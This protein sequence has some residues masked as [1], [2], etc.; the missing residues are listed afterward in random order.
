MRTT[1]APIARRGGLV[2]DNSPSGEV[3]WD[4]PSKRSVRVQLPLRNGKP[5]VSGRPR[6]ELEA[7]GQLRRA[8]LLLER[9]DGL[10]CIPPAAPLDPSCPEGKLVFELR[11]STGQIRNSSG[12]SSSSSEKEQS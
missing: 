6:K 3:P 8:G 2:G 7:V 11:R 4:A 1:S 10:A 5:G 9:S 12:Y